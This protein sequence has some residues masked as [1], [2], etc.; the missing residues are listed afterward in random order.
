VLLVLQVGF[1]GLVGV[2]LSVFFEAVHYFFADFNSNFLTDIN[3]KKDMR[4]GVM[5]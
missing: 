3:K 2:A 5:S 4:L 1:L